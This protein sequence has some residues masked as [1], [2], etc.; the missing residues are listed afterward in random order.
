MISRFEYSQLKPPFW[1]AF[2]MGNT[3]FPIY[4]NLD[5]VTFVGII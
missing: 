1:E 2:L 5:L 4:F 3:H